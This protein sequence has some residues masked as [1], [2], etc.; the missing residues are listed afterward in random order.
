MSLTHLV[1]PAGQK[2]TERCWGLLGEI[3]RQDPA[4]LGLVGLM[5]P[6]ALDQCWR[7]ELD[8]WEGVLDADEVTPQ[9][10][11]RKAIRWMRRNPPPPARCAPRRRAAR[12]RH[13][14]RRARS[15]SSD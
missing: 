4:K 3:S 6:V 7:R 8:Y 10:I 11:I 1:M 2:L 15:S 5:E 13:A 12:C 9:P 14:G